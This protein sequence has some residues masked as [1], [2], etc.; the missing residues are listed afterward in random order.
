MTTTDLTPFC[1]VDNDE[2]LSIPEL[3]QPFRRGL[4]TL[5]TDQNILVRVPRGEGSDDDTGP[6]TAH[7]ER[8]I[9]REGLSPMPAVRLPELARCQKCDGIG[10][11]VQCECAAFDDAC[12][13]CN[14]TRGLPA[15]E[16]DGHA[17]TCSHCLGRKVA[18][19]PGDQVNLTPVLAIAPRYYALLAQL[20]N[21]RVD[22]SVDSTG[23]DARGVSFTFDG[24]DGLMPVVTRPIKQAPAYVA[25][26]ARRSAIQ[27]EAL[28]DDAF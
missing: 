13:F 22:L 27:A 14:F 3:N 25:E 28:A 26:A 17:W 10:K 2:D 9:V 5:A 4:Y 18:Y 24:G 19:P 20:P 23:D 15:H 8:Q 7:L 11:V 16:S 6:E 1:F 12:E 21:V